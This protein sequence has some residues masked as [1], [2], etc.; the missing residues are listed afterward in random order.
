MDKALPVQSPAALNPSTLA[1][2]LSWHLLHLPEDS[3]SL[4]K[5]GLFMDPSLASP[6]HGMS[7]DAHAW[8]VLSVDYRVRFSQDNVVYMHVYVCIHT[9]PLKMVNVLAG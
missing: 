8:L 3:S 5:G 7:P 4:L 6:A 2:A 1:H 9:Y